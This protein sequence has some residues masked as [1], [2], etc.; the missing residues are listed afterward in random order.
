MKRFLSIAVFGLAVAVVGTTLAACGTGIGGAY[1]AKVN[2]TIIK[3]SDLNDELRTIRDNQAYQEA[4]SQGGASVLGTGGKKTFNSAFVANLLT[5]RVV[6]VLILQELR[7]R[8]LAVDDATRG[9]AEQQVTQRLTPQGGES[10]L[11]KFKKSYRDQLIERTAELITLQ[12]ALVTPPD[13]AAVTKFYEDN[14]D[15]F[16]ENC[17]RMILVPTKAEADAARARVVGGEDFAKVADELNQPGAA[18]PGGDLGCDISQFVP[19][20]R[21][22]AA[23]IPVNE[24]SQPVQTQFG[25]HVLQVTKR[26]TRP[27]DADLKAQLRQ[28]LSQG[29]SQA[30]NTLLL[31]LVKR[32][33]VTVNP[34]IG[35]FSKG[36]QVKNEPPGVVP[37]VAPDTATSLPPGGAPENQPNQPSQP[38]QPNPSPQGP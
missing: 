32:A 22:V 5:E 30:L 25:Y 23:T 6:Y 11:P 7:R 17:V 9:E 20:F 13:D 4:L 35:H 26:D 34:A 18:N 3:Q 8:G 14:K 36:D 2:H 27:L 16:A 12:S 28:Q 10:L 33:K 38:S 37:N 21:N 29:S 31:D 19:E 24:I 15:Q 1:A